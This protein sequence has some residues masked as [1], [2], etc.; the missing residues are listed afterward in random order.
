MSKLTTNILVFIA[1]ATV[2][3]VAT[4]YY[5]K[6]KY[7]DFEEIEYYEEEDIPVE[8]DDEEDISVE[9]DEDDISVENNIETKSE[10]VSGLNTNKPNIIDY[11]DKLKK[12]SYTNYSN[13]EMPL[14][15][16]EVAPIKTKEENVDK[17]TPYVISP[18][19]FG[20]EDGYET[21]S[22]TYYQKN[23]IVADDMDE[24]VEDVDKV[25]GYESLAHF[26]EYE[27]D[28]VFVRNDRLKVDY[29]ILLDDRDY[30][31]VLKHKPYLI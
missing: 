29:E 23:D 8:Y 7:G 25:I 15:E 28:S 13:M 3:S 30:E 2:G 11:A 1:G 20:E 5:M 24:L 31:D 4:W 6:N 27:D 9:Y 19:D 14:L 26:G 12:E 21:I 16:A 17:E 22:L 18:D 10:T